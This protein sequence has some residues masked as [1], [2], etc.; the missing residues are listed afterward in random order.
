[1]KTLTKHIDC[2]IYSFDVAIDRD[3]AIRAMEAFP[4]L[5]A[6]VFEQAKQEVKNKGNKK[7]DEFDVLIENIRA[8][9]TSQ[10]MKSEENLKECVKFAFPLMLAKA[11]SD[12]NSE[13][14]IAYI[15]DNNV[16]DEFNIGIYEMIMLGFTQSEVPDKPK[17]NFAMR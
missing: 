15:Y 5:A 8:K 10:M 14:V 2:G 9:T 11:G 4:D 12:L 13:E 3:I 1:M 17:V 16:D 6:Y 7:K